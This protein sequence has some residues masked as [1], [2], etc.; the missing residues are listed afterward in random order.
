[1]SQFQE[2]LQTEERK[3]G[4]TEGQKDGRTYPNSGGPKSF[5]FVSLTSITVNIVSSFLTEP[6]S[7]RWTCHCDINFQFFNLCGKTKA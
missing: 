3:D 1:M 7:F 5:G 6:A 4:K 2:N